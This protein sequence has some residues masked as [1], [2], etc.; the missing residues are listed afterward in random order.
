MTN[1]YNELAPK[2]RSRKAFI[3]WAEKGRN[4]KLERGD[5]LA[6]AN[7][8][9]IFISSQENTLD[10]FIGALVGFGNLSH[11]NKY[12]LVADA[13]QAGAWNLPAYRNTW[14]RL[15]IHHQVRFYNFERIHQ[16]RP[17]ASGTKGAI[18]LPQG[19]GDL[20]TMMAIFG[21]R[22]LFENALKFS[23]DAFD[24]GFIGGDIT[25]L[26]LIFPR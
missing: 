3:S 8:I 15:F 18:A 23:L 19:I 11:P 20:V 22:N 13:L 21:N 9:N 1:D 12:F 17:S 14:L 26:T 7:E 6:A 24:G 5:D 2:F 16:E 4:S 10:E 25:Y